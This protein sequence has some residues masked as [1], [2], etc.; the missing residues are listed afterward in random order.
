M[1]EDRFPSLTE[2]ERAQREDVGVQPFGGAEAEELRTLR[3]CF[4]T[5]RAALR[6]IDAALKRHVPNLPGTGATAWRLAEDV[7]SML[8]FAGVDFSEG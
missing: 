6:G 8:T 4:D 1:S 5:Y 2:I 3:T 7:R